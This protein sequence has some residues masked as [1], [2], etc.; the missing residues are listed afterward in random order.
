M[1][2]KETQPPKIKKIMEEFPYKTIEGV[3]K[4][5]VDNRC[6]VYENR[7]IICNIE[8]TKEYFPDLTQDEYIKINVDFCNTLQEKFQIPK[9]YRVWHQQSQQ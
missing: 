8:K 5:L 1:R 4:K 3:C 9:K 7:P 6:T 2:N